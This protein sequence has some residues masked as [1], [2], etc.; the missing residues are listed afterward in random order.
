[1]PFTDTALALLTAHLLA[2]FMF[3]TGWMVK[4]KRRP[5]VL[6]LHGLVVFALSLLAL[7]GSVG[8]VLALTGA[9]LVIDAV[10]V[11]A[12][13]PRLW[14]YLADQAAHLATIAVAALLVPDAFANGLWA[15]APDAAAPIAAFLCGL[16]AATTAGS[17][18]VGLL[19]A[20]LQAD[21]PPDGLQ[22]AGRVIGLLERALIFL[23]V[24]IDQPAGIGFLIAAKSI[25]RFDTVSKDR[26]VT[27]YIII[28]T[29][30][31]FGWALAVAL[32]T[33]EAMKFL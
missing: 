18:A 1:M 6:A 23:M 17:Y 12:L 20:G 13:P 7:G 3:Q 31:S 19:M 5:S 30:A 25:L 32:A 10:K 15:D 27:E 22:N 21:A 16:I 8:L 14:P 24:M 26:Q 29:L 2:D 11:Y 28:G 4:Y 33:Q 9:H